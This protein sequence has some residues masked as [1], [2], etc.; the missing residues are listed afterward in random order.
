MIKTIKLDVKDMKMKTDK[1][2]IED[3]KKNYEFSNFIQLI[4]RNCGTIKLNIK[5]EKESDVK[6]V[7]ECHFCNS[8]SDI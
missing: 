4:C 5:N 6:F 7:F 3:C 2:I 1:Q 8:K